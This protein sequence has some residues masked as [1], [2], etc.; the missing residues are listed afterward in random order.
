M[1]ASRI[2][3]RTDGAAIGLYREIDATAASI[4]ALWPGDGDRWRAFASPYVESFDAL[5]RTMLAGF[6][7]VAGPARLLAG[8]GVRGMVDFVR[9]L[10]MPAEALARELFR[11]GGPAGVAARSGAALRRPAEREWQRDRRGISE[12]PRPRRGLAEPG[13]GGRAASP[14]R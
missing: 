2:R 12:H 10:L 5:R 3:C 7:P 13:R 6:P 9:L 11:G 1:S 8:I 14:G 4:D